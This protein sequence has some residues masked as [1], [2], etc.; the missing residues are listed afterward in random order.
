M[1]MTGKKLGYIFFGFVGGALGVY[2]WL[3]INTDGMLTEI[4]G[5]SSIT[6]AA[7][8]GSAA[9]DFFVI[10]LIPGMLA[11]MAF[12]FSIYRAIRRR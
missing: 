4:S 1:S 12:A 11:I 10:A 7:A 6:I 3:A 5:S 2:T 9:G 8:N